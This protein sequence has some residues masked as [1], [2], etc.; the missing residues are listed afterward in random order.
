MFPNPHINKGE[1]EEGVKKQKGYKIRDIKRQRYAL[2]DN[3][4]LIPVGRWELKWTQTSHRIV[5]GQ[6]S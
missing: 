4:N 3:P 6:M 5:K 1:Q 2:A